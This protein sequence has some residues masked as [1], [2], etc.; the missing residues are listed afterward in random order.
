MSHN[1]L[2]HFVPA[3][4]AAHFKF[5]R[6][7]LPDG[8]ECT[9]LDQRVEVSHSIKADMCVGSGDDPHVSVIKFVRP[10][11]KFI[12]RYVKGAARFAM[13]YSL[14]RAD[15][16]L[17]LDQIYCTHNDL[18]DEERA[19]ASLLLQFAFEHKVFAG[20]GAWFTRCAE[21]PVTEF[22]LSGDSIS[23]RFRLTD[24]DTLLTQ[25]RN[26]MCDAI[27]AHMKRLG[28]DKLN[29]DSTGRR[30][31]NKSPGLDQLTLS[32]R[33]NW[34]EPEDFKTLPLETIQQIITELGIR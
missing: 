13:G 25:L 24:V 6:E 12:L 27:V 14:R 10:T 17:T 11:G 5:I 20:R 29:V 4:G 18:T 2:P 34:G 32:C 23:A 21:G 15:S 22:M 19:D 28:V 1:T 26:V 8:H 16:D 7:M 33:P 30:G 31:I 3:T 9:F